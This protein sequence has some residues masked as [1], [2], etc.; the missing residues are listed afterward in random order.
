MSAG[1]LDHFGGFVFDEEAGLE[2]GRIT[3]LVPCGGGIDHEL[4]IGRQIAL[5]LTPRLGAGHE[6]DGNA[7]HVLNP[8]VE[9]RE[10]LVFGELQDA[11]EQFCIDFEECRAGNHEQPVASIERDTSEFGDDRT[12]TYRRGGCTGADVARD[13]AV[14]EV[15]RECRSGLRDDG[16]ITSP[17]ECGE[18]ESDAML[19][20]TL[21]VPIVKVA[22]GFDEEAAEGAGEAHIERCEGVAE[23][24][25][26][27]PCEGIARRRCAF[28]EEEELRAVVGGTFAVED[29]GVRSPV[30][31]FT[32][33][34]GELANLEGFG[35][36]RPSFAA[37]MDTGG[38]DATHRE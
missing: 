11:V 33:D 8:A 7:V 20:D 1:A 31:R 13:H 30:D 25:H 9:V 32:I 17:A 21:A 34:D 35:Q 24:G 2:E 27:V 38:H 19:G 4:S 26:D 3:A 37:R 14:V 16:L 6:D 28:G 5:A 15:K 29:S 18:A 23:C 12:R 10:D 22:F 36:V